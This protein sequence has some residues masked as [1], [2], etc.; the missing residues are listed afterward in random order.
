MIS[1]DEVDLVVNLPAPGGTELKNNYLTRRTAVDFGIPLLTNAQ[2][3]NMF[4]ESLVKHK[5]GKITFTQVSERIIYNISILLF[6]LIL[7]YYDNL[8]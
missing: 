3:F 2:L 4:V 5:E 1:N 7:K 6:V 8:I